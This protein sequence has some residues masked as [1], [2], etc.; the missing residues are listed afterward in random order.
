V[1]SGLCILSQNI[2]NEKIFLILYFW[3]FFLFLCSLAFVAYRLATLFLPAFREWLILTRARSGLYLA[4]PLRSVLRRTNAGDWFVLDQICKNVDTSFFLEFIDQLSE[5]LGSEVKTVAR[6]RR[7][8]YDV[9][10]NNGGE[11]IKLLRMEE[12]KQEE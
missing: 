7:K 12:A 2:V 1:K 4:T 11:D 9:S 6:R 8:E 3:Y 5:D 10:Q